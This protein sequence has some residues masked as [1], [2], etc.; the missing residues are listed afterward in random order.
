MDVKRFMSAGCLPCN[1]KSISVNG[2]AHSGTHRQGSN[3]GCD[4]AVF[5]WSPEHTLRE[6]VGELHRVHWKIKR[7]SERVNPSVTDSVSS[8]LFYPFP[9]RSM[10][11]GL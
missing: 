5:G 4:M 6:G 1:I 10:G 3:P 8:A 2:K 11:W 9:D 7:V